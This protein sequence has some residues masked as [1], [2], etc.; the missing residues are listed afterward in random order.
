MTLGFGKIGRLQCLGFVHTDL[1][2]N[3]Y[4]MS[5]NCCS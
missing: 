5:Q 3:L 4:K 1:N 2:F